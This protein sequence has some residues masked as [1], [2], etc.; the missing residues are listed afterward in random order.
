MTSHTRRASAD[1]RVPKYSVAHLLCVMSIHPDLE[2][3][4]Q[5]DGAR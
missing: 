3:S 4:L 5:S 1:A 2:L